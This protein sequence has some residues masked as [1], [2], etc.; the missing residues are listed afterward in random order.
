MFVGP[1]TVNT[2]GSVSV[3]P[4]LSVKELNEYHRQFRKQAESRLQRVLAAFADAGIHW[5]PVVGRG[6]PRG[7][8]FHE[9]VQRGSDLIA[10]GTHGRSGLSHVLL[11]SVAEWLIRNA[12]CDILVARPHRFSFELP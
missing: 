1:V 3:L 7:I 2:L 12:Q 5:K 6:D 11:G 9:A 10:V 4:S 8:V